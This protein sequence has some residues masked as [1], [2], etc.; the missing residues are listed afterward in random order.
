LIILLLL[1]VEAAAEIMVVVVQA[2]LEPAHRFLSQLAQ[3]IQLLSEEAGLLAE[4][5]QQK[6]P[7]EL[8]LF[9]AP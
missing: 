3:H 8:I 9:L 2:G 5:V 1:A 4:P 6:V 7:Q